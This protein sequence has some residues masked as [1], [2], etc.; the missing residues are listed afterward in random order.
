MRRRSPRASRSPTAS[1]FMKLDALLSHY[2]QK[3]LRGHLHRGAALKKVREQWPQLVGAQLA[4]D[5]IPERL[6]GSV[7][8]ARARSSVAMAALKGAKALIE[9]QRQRLGLGV[10][11]SELR[12]RVGKV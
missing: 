3:E 4:R 7:L 10:H 12:C 2:E 1:P 8:Y 9:R 5:T 6:E 11:W